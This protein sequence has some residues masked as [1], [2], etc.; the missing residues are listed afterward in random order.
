MRFLKQWRGSGNEQTH[1]GAGRG[2]EAWVIEHA[3]VESGHAHHCRRSRQETENLVDI[4]FREEKH[5]AASQEDRIHSHEQPVRVINRQGVKQR[6]VRRKLPV[7][8]QGQGVGGKIVV[9][10]HGAF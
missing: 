1:M 4:E 3:H 9:G 5:R 6:F 10:Q 2:C 7:I 8:D